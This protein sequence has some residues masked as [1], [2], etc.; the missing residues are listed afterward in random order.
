MM[1]MLMMMVMVDVVGRDGN[2]GMILE[3]VVVVMEI[4]VIVN[5]VVVVVRR[6]MANLWSLC[7]LI[8]IVALVGITQ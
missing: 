5:M 4:L 6:I 3:M 1:M 2:I 8:K 7:H